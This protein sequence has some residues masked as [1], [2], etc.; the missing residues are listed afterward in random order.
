MSFCRIKSFV[1]ISIT[2]NS[3][4]IILLVSL[5]FSTSQT[6]LLQS[7]WTRF[8]VFAFTFANISFSESANSISRSYTKCHDSVLSLRGNYV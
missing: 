1:L 7:D 3:I 5:N 6:R 8:R 4:I 2:E